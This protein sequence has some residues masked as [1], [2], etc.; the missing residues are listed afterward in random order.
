MD[1]SEITNWLAGTL[2][3]FEIIDS[4]EDF[5]GKFQD[6]EGGLC[7]IEDEEE[8]DINS[9][10]KDNLGLIILLGGG[11]LLVAFLFKK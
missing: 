8:F 11:L 3:E 9:F 4:L 7:I 5:L 6:K 10:F 1:E 2:T